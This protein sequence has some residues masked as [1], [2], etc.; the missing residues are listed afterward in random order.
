M[1]RRAI[2]QKLSKAGKVTLFEKILSY[3]EPLFE[4]I[5]RQQLGSNGSL[6]PRAGDL[7]LFENIE[8]PIKAPFFLS[9][10]IPK[11]I[12]FRFHQGNR[13]LAILASASTGSSAEIQK[14]HEFE[15]WLFNSVSRRDPLR[16][17]IKIWGS[18]G[19]VATARSTDELIG[20]CLASA[21]YGVPLYKA[22]K[23]GKDCLRPL[24]TT[25]TIDISTPLGSE[26]WVSLD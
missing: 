14:L 11:S 8:R 17:K 1:E 22:I 21:Q 18:N 9:C 13:Q 3:E 2:L 19:F 4:K 24:T 7:L 12:W 20:A 6:S 16:A 23:R 10:D 15:G 5:A 26:T 25:N